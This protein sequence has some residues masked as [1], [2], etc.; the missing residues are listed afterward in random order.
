MKILFPL[1]VFYPSQAGGTANT[2]YWLTRQLRQHGI[3]PLIVASDKGLS[4]Q[5]ELNRWIETDAGRVLFVKTPRLNFPIRQTLRAMARLPECDVVHVSSVFYPAAFALGIVARILRKKLVWSIHGELD[6]PALAHSSGRK[7]PILKMIQLLVGKYPTFHTTC[8][9]ETGYVR[10]WFGDEAKVVEVTNYLE[11]A[12]PAARRPRSY[13]LF[14]G[15]IHPK[16]GIDN[17]IRAAAGC[18]EFIESAFTL[19]IAGKGRPEVEEELKLLAAELGVASKIEFVGQVEGHAKEQL[20]ADAHWTFMP[21]H[22][23]NFGLV[24]VESL[25]QS[26]PVMAST[27]SPW[28]SVEDE[29]VGI[30]AGNSVSELVDVL[31]RVLAI[32]PSDYLAMRDRCRPFVESRFDIADNIGHWLN[33]YKAL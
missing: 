26:T 24:I 6:P 32:P 31:R 14:L 23:E 16:K 4:G 13:L 28:R 25:A 17:L 19:K 22:S 29:R 9:E 20:L 11:I 18:P 7:A 8:A 33:L 5:V 21:S 3:E 30:W 15:R 2:V 12:A 1:E 27:G 10:R